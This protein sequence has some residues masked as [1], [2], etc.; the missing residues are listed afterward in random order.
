[1]K[2]RRSASPDV[3]PEAH[4]TPAGS[5]RWLTALRNLAGF[6]LI[7]GISLGAAWGVRRYLMTSPRFSLEQVIIEGQR[8]RTKEDLMER[9]H[10]K[11]GQ[12]V[13]QIDLEGARAAMLGDPYVES[14]TLARRLPDTLLVHIEERV[15]VAVVVIGM[16][17]FLVTRDGT[18]FKKLG[19]GDSADLP[20]ITGLGEELAADRDA[21][22]DRVRRA[23]DAAL[24]YQQSPMGSKLALQ[25]I[26]FDGD[27]VTLSVGSQGQG[28]VSLVLGRAPWRR[29]L[30]EAARVVAELERR[31]QKPDVIMLD[32][33]ARPER[34]VA[35]VR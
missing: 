11:V 23:L 20:V 18:T 10:L 4:E 29:K 8:T 16:D 5:P 32:Q 35:R 26:H 25:E 17:P 34:V 28:V 6:A 24:D 3:P 19:V 1:M 22:A 13:F 31:G 14:A 7:A 30:D 27:A 2:N 12:N 33:A 9:A 15:P 21:F